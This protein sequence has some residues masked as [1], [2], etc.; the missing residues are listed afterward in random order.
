MPRAQRLFERQG[1]EVEAFPVDFKVVARALTPMDFF[2]DPRALRMTDV[3]VR[4]LLGRLYY[5]IKT[6]VSNA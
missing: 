1:F 5:Q 4:E 6:M 2:P 3:L